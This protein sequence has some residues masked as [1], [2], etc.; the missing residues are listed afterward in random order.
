MKISISSI[1]E[2]HLPDKWLRLTAADLTASPDNTLLSREHH[3]GQK[4]QGSAA[5]IR[6]PALPF[7]STVLLEDELAPWL[8]Q[9]ARSSG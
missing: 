4:S 1:A 3:A 2:V 9:A 6:R 5:R 7:L 8:G